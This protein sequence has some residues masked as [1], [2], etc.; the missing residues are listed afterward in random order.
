MQKIGGKKAAIELSISTIVI[1]V[2]GVSMLI[3]GL[4]LVRSIFTGAKNV[5]DMTDDQLKAQISAM[6]G[7]DRSIVVYPDSKQIDV[8]Q[9]KKGDFGIGI[10]NRIQG[11]AADK[12][13]SY[14]VIVSDAGVQKKCGTTDAAMLDLITVG[15]SEKDIPIASGGSYSTR[16]RF[17]TSVGDPQCTVRFRINVRVNSE[18]Y[19]SESMDVTFKAA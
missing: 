12:K 18:I 9:G 6:F 19:G 13:F 17:E 11:S 14:E 1:V 5:A 7:D 3:L 16:V 10:K 15:Q 4:V 2:L 8:V